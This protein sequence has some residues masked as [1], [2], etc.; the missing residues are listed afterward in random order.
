MDLES[1]MFRKAPSAL[2][3]YPFEVQ[4]TSS[5]FSLLL[6]TKYDDGYVAYLNGVEVARECAGPDDLEL[7]GNGLTR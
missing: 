2:M 6:R 1:L 4:D 3:R 5:V 7:Q